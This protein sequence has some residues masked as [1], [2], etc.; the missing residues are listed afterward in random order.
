MKIHTDM[1]IVKADLEDFADALIAG[2]TGTS[3]H[4][5]NA[6]ILRDPNGQNKKLAVF[7][8]IANC[9]GCAKSIT[10]AVNTIWH[11]GSPIS[12]QLQDGACPACQSTSGFHHDN[13][14]S[15]Q[16]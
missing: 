11:R 14:R 7:T 15:L 16:G 13:V 12:I 9:A 4:Q 1:Q 6:K 3:T 10:C 2:V 5:A 8:I